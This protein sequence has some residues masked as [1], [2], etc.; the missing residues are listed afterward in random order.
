MKL[1]YKILGQGEPLII[2]HGFLG[3]LDNWMTPAHM[4]EDRFRCIVPDMRNHG[5]SPH[6]SEHTYAAMVQ[7]VLQL[8]DH[9]GLN[10]AHFIGHSMGGKVAMRLAQLHPGRL[11]KLVV[12]D[13]GPKSYPP[14][15]QQIFEALESVPLDQLKKRTDADPYLARYISDPAVRQFLMKNLHRTE[16]G[17]YAWRFNLPVLKE[18]MQNIGEA[19][20]MDYYSGETLFV[21]GGKSDYITDEDW[22]DIKVIFPEAHLITIENA[23][24]WVHAEQPDEFIQVV[25][26]FLSPEV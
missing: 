18:A 10:S 14:H 12:V 4:L 26:D 9:L 25:R 21:R 6:S 11:K 13:I 17:G 8:M 16:Q 7:D 3:M 2:I 24:H 20:D 1:N 22:A 19:M 5:R 23:G 15:H